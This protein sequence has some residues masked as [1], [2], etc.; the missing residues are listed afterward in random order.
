[1]AVHQRQLGEL[2]CYSVVHSFIDLSSG[3]K[4]VAALVRD[5]GLDLQPSKAAEHCPQRSG[6]RARGNACAREAVTQRSSEE[7]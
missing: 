7:G 3:S 5:P 1:M 4:D 6:C 2:F